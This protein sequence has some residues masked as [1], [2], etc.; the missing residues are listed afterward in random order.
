MP[1]TDRESARAWLEGQPHQ[2]QVA[3]AARCAL[4]A[5]PAIMN[6]KDA[7]LRGLALPAL[8]AILTSGVAGTCPIPEVMRAAADAS[9][10]ASANAANAAAPSSSAAANASSSAYA[11]SSSANA[12]APSSAYAAASAANAAY[13]AADAAY[14]ASS[15]A[16]DAAMSSGEGESVDVFLRP[17]WPGGALP[18]GLARQHEKLRSFWKDA[19][20]VWTFWQ[21]WYEDML[22]GRPVDWDFLRQVVL[23]PDEDWKRGPAHVA[24]LIEKLRAKRDLQ[25]SIE[26]LEQDLTGTASSRLGLG[27]NNPPEPLDQDSQLPAGL[28]I[29]WAPLQEMKEEAEKQAPDPARLRKAT[30]ALILALAEIA[31]WCG[32][33]LDRATDKAIDW[34]VPAGLGY[35]VLHQ[36]KIRA[37]IEAA[38]AFLKLH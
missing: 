24:R 18:E 16:A 23:L 13:A 3:F 19:A 12:A 30:D 38:E 36:D 6:D 31:T 33:K 37:V 5:L 32:R 21:S 25:G 9:A 17:L 28:L 11:A 1:I 15:S 20:P 35:L 10:Y 27:G 14:A 29:V 4:R 22:A 34:G 8:R 2:V 26:D 7:A